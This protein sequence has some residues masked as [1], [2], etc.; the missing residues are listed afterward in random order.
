MLEGYFEACVWTIG[1]E[2]LDGMTRI[3]RSHLTQ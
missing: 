2:I 3:R 1:S